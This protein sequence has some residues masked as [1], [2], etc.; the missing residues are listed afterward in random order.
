MVVFDGAMPEV[1]RREIQRRRD[2]REKL[3]REDDDGDD[4]GGGAMRRTAKKLLVH[5]LKEWRVKEAKMKLGG[6]GE[7]D[8]VQN[9][10]DTSSETGAFAA[11]FTTGVEVPPRQTTQKETSEGKSEDVISVQCSDDEEQRLT[12]NGADDWEMARVIQAS[13]NDTAQRQQDETKHQEEEGD[14]NDWELAH[15]VH[16]S[17]QEAYSSTT[18]N[19]YSNNTTHNLNNLDTTS[20]T[21][22]QANE[23][24][25]SLP[26][27]TRSQWIDSQFRA[28]RIQSRQECINVAANMEEYSS[29][30][31]RNFLKGSRLNKR[32]NEI[33]KLAG[34]MGVDGNDADGSAASASGGFVDEG[35]GNNANNGRPAL[36]RLRRN[37]NDDDYNSEDDD[38]FDSSNGAAANMKVLFGE[39]DDEDEYGE[40]GFLPP[41]S[42]NNDA[43]MALIHRPDGKDNAIALD[44]GDSDEGNDCGGFLPSGHVDKQYEQ[45]ID[46]A[47]A[48]SYNKTGKSEDAKESL[49]NDTKRQPQ[50]SKLLAFSSADREWEEWGEEDKK[51]ESESIVYSN[52]RVETTAKSSENVIA[53][54]ASDSDDDEPFGSFLSIGNQFRFKDDVK[55]PKPSTEDASKATKEA[56]SVSQPFDADDDD[57]DEGIDWEDGEYACN[58]VNAEDVKDPHGDDSTVGAPA[59]KDPDGKLS[60]CDVPDRLYSDAS[61]NQQITSPLKVAARNKHHQEEIIDVQSSSEEEVD[62]DDGVSNGGNQPA[63]EH[64]GDNEVAAENNPDQPSYPT[65]NTASDDKSFAV[66]LLDDDTSENEFESFRPTDRNTEALQHAQETASRLTSWAGRAVKRALEAH[67]G[68]SPDEKIG[69]KKKDKIDLALENTEADDG[70]AS[71]DVKDTTFTHQP[72]DSPCNTNDR[73]KQALFDTTLE[74]LNAAHNAILDEER[75]MERDI[76]TITDEMKEDILEL[77]ELCGIPWVESPSEAE[78]QC[79]ALEELGLVD[80]VVTEDSDIFVFGGRK[81]YKVS[82]KDFPS[83]DV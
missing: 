65:N 29:T 68:G 62:W 38:V 46:T 5:Q 26:T 81:V 82:Y 27:E 67:V 9:S 35:H 16:G 52:V 7:T 19:Q 17:L 6:K 57:D 23:T 59:V 31:L 72:D 77:L 43:S 39:D 61:A 78:A 12:N 74:G 8:G 55:V 49:A 13:L 58:E 11:G 80:G 42:A 14:D 69:A 45:T 32:M 1:K 3:W 22:E 56:D 2:R 30:Q 73:N 25:A 76:S 54:D 33:G 10:C 60:S 36:Q 18:V 66:E 40:G 48:P 15:A 64:G 34:K 50:P 47:S 21:T 44:D 37:N 75:N 83:F 71:N 28:Q 63:R 53:L 70:N 51:E 20:T 41:T 4:G 79:A 24:I